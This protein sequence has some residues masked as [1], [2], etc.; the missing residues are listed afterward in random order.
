MEDTTQTCYLSFS[1]EYYTTTKMK[2]CKYA[3]INLHEIQLIMYH[4]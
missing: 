3:M 4:A 2:I 1:N